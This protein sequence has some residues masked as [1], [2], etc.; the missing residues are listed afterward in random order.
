[1]VASL[2]ASDL[3]ESLPGDDSRLRLT[4]QGRARNDEIRS[5]IAVITERLYGDIPAADLA[6]AGRVLS[7]VTARANA[8]LAALR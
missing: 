3:L 5:A 4:D 2:A 6:T 1:V 7:L 8:E